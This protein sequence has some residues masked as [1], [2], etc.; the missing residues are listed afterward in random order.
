MEDQLQ[1][2]RAKSSINVQQL[3]EVLYGGLDYVQLR[4]KFQEIVENDPVF[5]HDDE[6]F[7]SRSERFQR[8]LAKALRMQQLKLQ[9]N[10]NQEESNILY[11]VI[12][13]SSAFLL[14]T[15]M[16]VP[17]MKSLYT[18]EQ[19]KE[20]D[21]KLDKMEVIGCYAQT[22]MGHGSN[23][24]ALETTAT[25]VPETDEFR[26][27]SPTLTSMKWWPGGLGK[28][29][30]HAM[31]I[32]R[33]VIYG[34]DYGIHNFVV[35]IRDPDTHLLLPGVE[36]GDIGPKMG[37]TAVD[38]GFLILKGVHIPRR[39]MA[40]KYTKVDREGNYSKANSPHA[41]I[42][43]I[44]MMEVRA[45][46]V[47]DAGKN[48]AKACTIATRYSAVRRQGYDDSGLK[49]NSVLTYSLQQHRL[50]SMIATSYAFYFTGFS[51]MNN[52]RRVQQAAL[53]GA[54]DIASAFSELHASSSGLKSLC[55]RI[56][57]DGI[58]DLRKACG[59]HGYL[60]ASGF[61][62]LSGTY[63]QSVTVEGDNYLL[64]QQVLKF[65]LKALKV[66]RKGGRM[67]GDSQYLGKWKELLN[68]SC[69]ATSMEYI[70]QPATILEAL[71]HRAVRLITCV[72]EVVGAGIMQGLPMSQAW[73]AALVEINRASRA[74]CMYILYKNFADAIEERSSKISGSNLFVLQKLR[75][76]FGLFWIESDMGDFTEDSYFSLEQSKCIREKVM[77]LLSEI[78]PDAIPLVDAFDYSDYELRSVLGRYDGNV[79]QALYQTTKI[80]PL[81]QKEPVEGYNEYVKPLMKVHSQHRS[82]L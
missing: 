31:V 48:L 61:P 34:K 25:F 28:V 64:T 17:I 30:T 29:S 51:M 50:F 27:D 71:G 14:H 55:T 39:Y 5:A 78:R 22:E 81:N 44:A 62:E 77:L 32:A 72:E 63:L 7:I 54:E 82:R 47:R 18:N 80:N 36:A 13:E 4:R 70:S 9:M 37:F 59:G 6:I 53:S 45:V 75:D 58:E 24:Q 12:G 73:N 20:W 41:K 10:L 52:F 15:L 16:F 33:L 40:M 46:I 35:P 67:S 3:T 57:A 60:L 74:H 23:I 69:K 79:Y 11:A 42:S 56:T 8:G 43:S 68:S 19:R 49:E 26:M 38:N 21:E 65:L 1:I 66:A 76:L 2:E